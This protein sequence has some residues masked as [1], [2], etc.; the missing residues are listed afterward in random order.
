MSRIGKQPITI[1][2]KVKVEIKRQ[3]VS[4]R[5]PKGKLNFDLPHHTS[6]KV[7]GGNVLVSRDGDDAQ[8]KALHGLQPRSGQQHGQGRR[9]KGS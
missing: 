4:A 5:C 9:A 2:P 6:L 8:A 3:K 1:P 7:E